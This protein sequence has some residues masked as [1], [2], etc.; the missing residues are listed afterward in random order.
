MS[1]PLARILVVDDEAAIR[2]I[3][4]QYLSERGHQVEQASNGV[5]ALACLAKG[6]FDLVVTDIRMP[7]MGGLEL[8]GHIGSGHYDV[9]VVMLTACDDVASAIQAMK[10]GALDYVLKPF[11]L[12]ELGGTVDRA[13]AAHQK[14]RRDKLQLVELEVLVNQQ[15]RQLRQIL[16]QLHDAWDKAL[17]AMVAALDV[18]EHEPESHSKRVSEYAARLASA[19]GVESNL[20]EAINRGAMLHDIGKIGIPDSVLL[21]PGKLTGAEW[22]QMRK[23]PQIGFWILDGIEVLKPA[24]EIVLTH[25]ENFDGTG[26]PAG[27]KGSEIPI[28]SRIFSVVD[29]LDAMTSDR[30]YRKAGSY[31]RARREIEEGA[32]VQYDPDVV[33]SFLSIP[34]S[35]WAEIRERSINTRTRSDPAVMRLFKVAGA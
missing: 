29:S 7:V 35:D 6:G 25:H 26:Y 9:G 30:P 17:D 18:R 33:R 12:E 3:L 31:Q 24:C 19:V 8:L 32:G 10:S 4:H 27:L 11:R 5:E 15:A 21:K 20:M 34:P 2:D 28:G 22:V 14:V 1:V 23:H 16:G 13:L